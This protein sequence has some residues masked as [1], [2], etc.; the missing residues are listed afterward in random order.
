MNLHIY[1]SLYKYNIVSKHIIKSTFDNL[2][3][4]LAKNRY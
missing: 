1:M 2:V 4:V 3:L